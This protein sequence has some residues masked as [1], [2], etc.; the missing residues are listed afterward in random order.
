MIRYFEQINDEWRQYSSIIEAYLELR[1]K[2]PLIPFASLLNHIGVW[3]DTIPKKEISKWA[4]NAANENGLKLFEIDRSTT[5]KLCKFISD[6]EI[7]VDCPICYELLKDVDVI[8]CEKACKV[9]Y[10]KKC[11]YNWLNTSISC[12]NCRS[13]LTS[14]R[15]QAR[16]EIVEQLRTFDQMTAM[17]RSV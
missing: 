12:P 10:H 3:D 16:A 1:E 6:E 7:F 13:S 17:L 14:A 11:I 4:R 2:A 9:V 15:L 5:R 8:K